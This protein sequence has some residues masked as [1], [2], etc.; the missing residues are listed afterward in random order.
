MEHEEKIEK[1]AVD[2]FGGGDPVYYLGE[3]AEPWWSARGNPQNEGIE[4]LAVSVNVLQGG[5]GELNTSGGLERR[6]EDEYRW[7]KDLKPYAR[8]GTSIF[9]Y[10]LPL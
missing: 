6:P 1:I 7:L 4:W 9:I 5:W 10:R 8:A 2:Y 3:K